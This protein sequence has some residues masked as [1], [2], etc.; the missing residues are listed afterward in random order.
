MLLL[1]AFAC[2]LFCF[3]MCITS[4]SV[5]EKKHNAMLKSKSVRN[6]NSIGPLPVKTPVDPYHQM[7]SGGDMSARSSNYVTPPKK[8]DK[9]RINAGPEEKILFEFKQKVD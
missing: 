2:I 9:A 5:G 7:E 3:V 6:T 8:D 4:I 1:L